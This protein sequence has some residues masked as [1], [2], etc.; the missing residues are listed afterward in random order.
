MCLIKLTACYK[1][2][3]EEL[4]FIQPLMMN[5]DFYNVLSVVGRTLRSLSCAFMGEHADD[6]VLNIAQNCLV[7]EAILL[8]NCAYVTDHSLTAIAN[9]CHSLT[10]F[11]IFSTSL[12]T[13]VGVCRFLA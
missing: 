2:P 10:S 8:R 3:V 11:N 12:I 5:D 6:V 7:L 9:H 4:V 1:H 13:D